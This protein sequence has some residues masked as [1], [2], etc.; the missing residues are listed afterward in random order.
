ML[1][2][3]WVMHVHL[4]QIRIFFFFKIIIKIIINIWIMI[5]SKFS[6]SHFHTMDSTLIHIWNAC[7]KTFITAVVDLQKNKYI[8]FTQNVRCMYLILDTRIKWEINTFNCRSGILISSTFSLVLSISKE[9][10]II[11]EGN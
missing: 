6:F 3:Y 10:L 5:C 9:Y 2:W 8:T 4:I 11:H 7:R 1:Q